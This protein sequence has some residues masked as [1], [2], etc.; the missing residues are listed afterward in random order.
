MLPLDP[1]AAT[2]SFRANQL[3]D[4]YSP[5]APAPAPGAGRGRGAR[6]G[7]SPATSSG[8]L[9]L[10]SSTAGSRRKQY[11]RAFS[12]WQRFSDKVV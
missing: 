9:A 5:Q 6:R 8:A 7:P 1:A 2:A 11:V 4:H 12:H 10:L 3:A